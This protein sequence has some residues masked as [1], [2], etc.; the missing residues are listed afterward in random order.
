MVQQRGRDEQK[1]K[2]Q[3]KKEEKDPNNFKKI[4]R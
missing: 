3:G 2:Q 1:Q 4:L